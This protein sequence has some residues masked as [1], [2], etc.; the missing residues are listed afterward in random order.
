MHAERF[1]IALDFSLLKFP[2]PSIPRSHPTIT[3]TTRKNHFREKHLK[4]F[5]NYQIH[6][7][8]TNISTVWGCLSN[9][10]SL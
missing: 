6:N 5:T 1:L 3:L 2:A 7:I 10:M 4:I 9:V 8:K